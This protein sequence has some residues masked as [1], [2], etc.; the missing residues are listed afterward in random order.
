MKKSL[1]CLLLLTVLAEAKTQK[2]PPAKSKA[3][4]KLST[5]VR[6]DNHTV[7]GKI[8]SPLEALSVVENEKKIDD[9]IG[10]RKNFNDRRQRAKGMR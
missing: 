8:Q 10:V 6:F 7:G 4:T 5:D 1:I 3:R 2:S 9:L